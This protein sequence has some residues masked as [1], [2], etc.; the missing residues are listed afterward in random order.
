MGVSI[1]IPV[2][3]EAK[4]VSKL[5]EQIKSVMKGEYEIIFVDDGSTDGTYSELLKLSPVKIIRFRKNFGQSAAMDA[6]LHAA[7]YD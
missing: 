2:K 4:N 3:D 1:V 5:H 6:G 7:K